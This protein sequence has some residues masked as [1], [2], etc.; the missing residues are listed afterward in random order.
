MSDRDRIASRLAARATETLVGR[1]D[2]LA[3]LL[4]LV[5]SDGPIVVHLSAP[6]GLGKSALLAIF[7]DRATRAGATVLNV[8]C[9]LVEPTERGFLAE[10][11]QL[12]G[13]EVET[14]DDAFSALAGA[15]APVVLVL[16]NY[17]T[18][19]LMDTWLRQSFL[20][21]APD[22]VRLVLAG[23]QPPVPRWLT[24]P[25]W[26]GLFRALALPPLDHQASLDLLA[27]A[28]LP[29]AKA[30]ATAAVW[31]GTSATIV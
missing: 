19:L 25:R 10:L 16:D 12:T 31:T 28:G 21:A 4:E 13:D 24:S 18:F 22:V 2:E 11:G 15:G 17:E 9:R 3:M 8:D 6:A 23:R 30:E 7:A 20:P 29:D 1:A 5:T 26:R 14:L 27:A